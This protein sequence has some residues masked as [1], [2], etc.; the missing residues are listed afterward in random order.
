MAERAKP[1]ETTAADAWSRAMDKSSAATAGLPQE[2]LIAGETLAASVLESEIKRK[3]VLESKASTFVVTPAIATAITAAIAPLTKDLQLS[4]AA[5]VIVTIAYALALIHLL[6]SSWYA[7]TV[8]RAEAFVV[9]SSENARRLLAE[10]PAQ[11]IATRLAYAEVNE[12]AL[13]RKANRLS[14]S[15]DLF[16]RGLAFLAFA[17]FLSLLAHI[18]HV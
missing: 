6:V 8:R 16:L 12:P 10:T 7:I 11:R 13:V 1:V 14:V 5:A 9:L 15:E 17:S 4:A 3:E 18:A 2:A